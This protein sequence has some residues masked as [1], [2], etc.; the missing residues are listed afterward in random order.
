MDKFRDYYFLTKTNL[1]MRILLLLPFIVLF[2]SACRQQRTHLFRLVESDES[3][4]HFANTLTESDTLNALAFEYI[5]N[6]AGVGTADFNN[7]GLIDIFFSG[8]L[9]SCRLYLNKGNLTFDDVTNSAGVTTN[10]WCTGV[11]VVDVNKDGLMDL[12]ISTIH[13]K[14]EKSTRNIFFINKGVDEKGIP[15]FEDL[16]QS[17]DVDDPGYSTQAAFVDYDLDGDLDMYLLNNALENYTRNAPVGQRTDGTGKS[18]DRLYRHDILPD[19]SIHFTDVS[20]AAG[21]LAEG[22]GLGIVVNDFNNDGWPDIYC[23]DDFL[24]SDHLYINQQDGTFLD[25]IGEC[26]NHQEFNGMGADMADLNND[27][28]N[29]LVVMDMMPD[30]N[31]RQKTMFSGIAYDR[32]MKSIQMKYQPQ[33]IRNVL[34]RNNGN[35]TFSDIGYMSGIYA[36][37]WSWSALLADFDN[38]GLRDIFITNGYPKDITDLD[39]VTYN[40][41]ATMFGTDELKKRSATKAIQDLGG[42]YKPNFLF[43]NKGDFQFENV[44]LTWGLSEPA[45]SNG[46]AYA[47]LD[48]D[49]DLD[50]VINNLNGVASLYENTINPKERNNANFIEV[51]FQGPQGNPQG[52]GAK[53]WVHVNDRHCYGEQQLQ[54]GYLSSVDPKMH[55][56]LGS[57][58]QA[59]SVVILWPG[60]REQVLHNVPANSTITAKYDEATQDYRRPK[61]NATLLVKDESLPALVQHEEEYA[62]YKYGQP[63]LPHKFSQ[64]GPALATGDINGD[65]LDDFIVGGTAHN[66]AKIFYQETGGT[67]RMDS[68]PVKES[69]DTG[70]CLFDADHDGDLDLYCVSGSS[71]FGRNIKRYQDRLYRNN[72]KGKFML[73]ETALPKIESSGSC[74]IAADYDKDGDL[75][76]FVGGRIVPLSYPVS[77]RSYVLRND[78]AGKFEDV[79]RIVSDGLDSVGMVTCALFS[80]FDNDGWK[81]LI[82]AGEWM[83]IIIFKNDG[84]H[85]KK[86]KELKTGWWSSLAEGDFDND[87]D[88]DYIAG[89]LGRNSVLQ[90]N[91]KEPVSIYAKDFDGNGSTDPIISRYVQGKEYPVHYRET[92]TDQV[93]SLKRILRTYSQYGKMEMPEIINFLGGQ[94]M[95]VMRADYFESSYLQNEGNGNFSLHALPLSIQVSPINSIAVCD[96]NADG[97]LDFLAV[98]NSFSEETLSG[99]YDAGIGVCALGKGDGTFEMLPPVKSGFC[100]RTDAKAIAVITAA[101]KR[102]WVITSNLAPV[103]LYQEVGEPPVIKL[104]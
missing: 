9:T 101:G 26:M 42:V 51:Q 72:G 83:P 103:V 22:W 30:D 67:F 63:T 11:S 48:N 75:D 44:A 1:P 38:D 16:A 69:E 46:A 60:E 50:L 21:V 14:K 87:G 6:G 102:K 96:L 62:D 27:G 78:G 37:D 3:G 100:V 98:G 35:N 55:F 32:F 39:F 43:H 28:L 57:A 20:K 56:G 86:I 76:L 104:Q 88:M 81:D 66:S 19:G 84:G 36:T 80:D 24:S 31:L 61:S 91:E 49:G 4:I 47:D 15:H 40:R 65:G 17:L 77:P 25:D 85:F 95:I 13:P 93:V 53:V 2:Q 58:T 34:Q 99:N 12:Y 45:Y 41:E 71:E 94:N 7:D 23:A 90:G 52:L 68:L 18:V 5:Y 92:M 97:H 54:R 79:T 33:Y 29:D 82:I 89:N 64:Q 73:D 8:N 74:V 10:V 70:L 59:D